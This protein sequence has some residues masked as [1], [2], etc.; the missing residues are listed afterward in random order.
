M[1]HITSTANQRIKAIRKLHSARGRKETGTTICE[2]P[3]LLEALTESDTV[4]LVVLAVEGD[5]PA[6]S[7]AR[8]TQAWTA[9]AK[10][11][12]ARKRRER[13]E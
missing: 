4:P 13:L 1:E 9:A 8:W 2:G 10:K 11:V 7:Q 12:E 3:H 5:R 6:F